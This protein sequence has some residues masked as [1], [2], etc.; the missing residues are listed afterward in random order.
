M[1]IE[2][3]E[4]FL[5]GILEGFYGR[6]WS[7]ET[8]LAYTDFLSRA[9]LNTCLYCPKADPYLRKQWQSDWP[10]AEW[11]QLLELS[12]AYR[13]GGIQWG[14]GLS[15]FALYLD[16]G[17]AQREQLKRKIGRLSQLEA[18][19]LAILFDDMPGDLATLASRQAEIVAD[20]VAW[21]PGVRLL[22]CPTYYAFDPVL[23]TFFGSMP[24]DYWS[25]I[26]AEIPAGVDIFWTG[27]KVCS[28]SITRVDIEGICT[29]LGRP[30]VL[31]DN[32]PVNDGAVRS[33]FL[34]LDKLSGRERLPKTLL[35]GH[36]C[37]PMNQG[38]L[39][40]PAL[41]GLA[42]LY[43]TGS[44][45]EHWIQEVIGK[46]T[47]NQLQRDQCAFGELGLSGMG[48][49]RCRALALQYRELPGPAAQEVAQWLSGDF[50]FDPACLTD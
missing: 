18:P 16:Y 28:D 41:S 48:E 37:N 1:T 3:G 13:Q 24:A 4:R 17:P 15:P 19:L 46:A 2:P 29:Q 47:W 50:H 43:G 35:N 34:Y 5:T 6:T 40:L 30:V 49:K 39:S 38:L 9:G 25:Q 45:D 42:E 22:V 14:V 8:R 12:R 32:Y 26:G 10:A 7:F 36:L 23:E 44:S 33:N 21:L 11:Q 31:W 27:N 20:V